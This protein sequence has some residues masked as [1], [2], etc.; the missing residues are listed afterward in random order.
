MRFEVHGVAEC[1]YCPA[2]GR[3]KFPIGLREEINAE[4]EREAI[5]AFLNRRHFCKCCQESG[6]R[7]NLQVECHT[8]SCSPILRLRDQQLDAAAD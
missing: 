2:L 5:D 8:V 3:V 6:V 4:S 7:V 1:P